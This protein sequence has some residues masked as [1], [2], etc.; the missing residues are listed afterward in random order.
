KGAGT[1]VKP[2]TTTTGR[3]IVAEWVRS[4]LGPEAVGTITPHSFRHYFVTRVLH[5]SG[6]LK[7]A[8]EL[9]R[10]KS[11]AVT[12]RYAH[13]ND[14]ELDRGYYDIFDLSK[15]KTDE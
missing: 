7:M 4:I 15:R 12:Q 8:Q 6:N 2:I 13:L 14:D 11:I 3:E 10:H 5:S 1:K 9:A